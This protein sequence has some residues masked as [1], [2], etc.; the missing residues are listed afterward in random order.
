MKNNE[1]QKVNLEDFH[2]SEYDG[3]PVLPSSSAASGDHAGLKKPQPQLIWFTGL[4]GAGKTT[5]AQAVEQS[6]KR[7]GRHTILLDGDT[8]RAGLCK[9]LGFSRADRIENLRRVVEVARMMLDAELMVLAAFISPF[10][11][12]RQRIRR[13]FELGEYIEVFVDA[14]LELCEQRDP[15]GLYLKARA[16][17]IPD[18]TDISSPYE[19]PDNPELHLETGLL[20]PEQ[21][22]T[23]VLSAIGEGPPGYVYEAT[24]NVCGT[25]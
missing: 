3:D 2:H 23:R 15:K 4:S 11:D 5:I 8:M 9:D 16:G 13:F 17:K 14:P 22:V 12:E 20:R 7:Q 10:L 18:F 6:L 24:S 1:K 25:S 19:I 21:C